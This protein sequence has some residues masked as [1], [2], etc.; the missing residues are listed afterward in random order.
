MDDIKSG[1]PKVLSHHDYW[2]AKL[3]GA[4]I[5]EA[6]LGPATQAA[7][8]RETECIKITRA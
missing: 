7:V 8:I 5:I 1:I 3:I 4:T 2:Y 6:D